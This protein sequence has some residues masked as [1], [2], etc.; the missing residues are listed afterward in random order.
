MSQDM[1]QEVY[2]RIFAYAYLIYYDVQWMGRVFVHML[3]QCEVGNFVLC[4]YR[5]L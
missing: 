1:V 3:E 4:R 2:C 5:T